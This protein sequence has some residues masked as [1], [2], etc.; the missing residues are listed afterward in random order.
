MHKPLLFPRSY[1]LPICLI[2]CLLLVA[3]SSGHSHVGEEKIVETPQEISV[4]A[5]EVIEGTLKDLLTDS[6][7]LAGSLPRRNAV[8]IQTL[9]ERN[10]FKPLWSDEGEFFPIADSLNRL[11]D[12]ARFFGLFSDDYRS[13][14]LT[15]MQTEL[16]DSATNQRLDAAKWAHSDLLLTA[17]FVQLV[18]DLKKGRLLP[19][20]V[21]T[22]DTALKASFF[23]AA[24]RR[25]SQVPLHA[26]TSSLEPEHKAY[27]QLKE[28]LV[29][30]LDSADFRKY[31]LVK[32]R[33]S[34]LLPRLLFRRLAE[35][36][37]LAVQDTVAAD[38]LS[39]AKAIRR[40][41]KKR[42]LR[43]DGRISSELVNRLNSTDSERF[44]RIAITLDKLKLLPT[45]PERYIWVNLP[46]FEL[47]VRD[48]DTVVLRSRVVVG[49][50]AT[51]TPLLTSRVTD[52]ITYPKWHIPESII[53]KDILP[54]LKRDPSYTKR[55]GFTLVDKEGNEVDPLS[56]K[57]ARYTESI[58]YRVVQGSGDDN[59]LGVM[60]FNF[61]NPYSVYLHDTN[62]R[63]LFSRKSR[64]LSHGCVRVQAWQELAAY[65]LRSDSIAGAEQIPVDS[66][67]AWLS[68]KEKHY[69]PVK[70]PIPLFIRYLTVSSKED[71][72]I[73]HEDIYGEDARLRAR[74]FAGK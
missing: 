5:V 34:L 62:Q 54:G 53:K 18:K 57:W 49:K 33:D 42:G 17:A 8:V 23:E 12:S 4:S 74:L 73:F 20:S 68:R 6:N 64:A 71:R 45:L 2:G 51:R 72:L 30:F 40:Y 28:A 55:K 59:A 25:L 37:S 41:Q 67:A 24:L 3:C 22:K 69:I 21:L 65:L 52:M 13:P 27:H 60:K 15:A 63:G 50:P 16:A 44:I 7:T 14:E 36:D 38:S 47:E 11:I 26:F 10:A 1:H 70:R 32:T 46:S 48:S 35:E 31:T 58:P 66:L 29:H 39:L 9:Y 61:P 56:V 19:D 43:V